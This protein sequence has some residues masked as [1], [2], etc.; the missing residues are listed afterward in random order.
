MTMKRCWDISQI[1]KRKRSEPG[2]LLGD[3]ETLEE[4]PFAMLEVGYASP[5]RL[6]I[7]QAQD[8]LELP[9]SARM[10]SIYDGE[11]WKWRL[12]HGS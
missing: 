12:R 7:F 11:N 3:E 8:L 10:I 1:E 4:I 2:E 9:D 5:A 6:V